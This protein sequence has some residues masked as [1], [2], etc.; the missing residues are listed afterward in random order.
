MTICSEERET[1]ECEYN[2][3]LVKSLSFLCPNIRSVFRGLARETLRRSLVQTSHFHKIL[4]VLPVFSL[5]N[6]LEWL[7]EY[8]VCY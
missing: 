8:S 6:Y 5:V 1:T 3:K 7:S 2:W 4:K